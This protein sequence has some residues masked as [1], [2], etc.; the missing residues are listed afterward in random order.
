MLDSPDPAVL[1]VPGDS[2]Q[3]FSGVRVVLTAAAASSAVAGT[4][5]E[6]GTPVKLWLGVATLGKAGSTPA[7]TLD[8]DAVDWTHI[9]IFKKS[10]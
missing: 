5:V 2:V 8:S 3:L 1:G 7:A 9:H 6:M 10:A 4:G